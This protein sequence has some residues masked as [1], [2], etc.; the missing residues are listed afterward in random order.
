MFISSVV[1][2]VGA[3]A[4]IIGVFAAIIAA[5]IVIKNKQKMDKLPVETLEATLIR[6]ESN[7]RFV[8]KNFSSET[9][10]R[11]NSYEMTDY[12]LVFK[13]KQGKQISLKVKRKIAKIYNDGDVGLLTYQA[14]KFINFAVANNKYLSSTEKSGKTVL[15]YGEAKELHIS[16]MSDKREKYN[17]A[18]IIALIEKLKTDNSDW[19]FVLKREDGSELQV[20]REGLDSVICTLKIAAKQT[21]K[22]MLINKMQKYILDYLEGLRA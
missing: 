12:Y 5:F 7:T 9:V 20:E 18:D 16:V 17:K 13:P 8:N 10:D 1:V 2:I 6:T 19:F 22:T 15:F 3:L 11:Y 21:N 14:N 4:A